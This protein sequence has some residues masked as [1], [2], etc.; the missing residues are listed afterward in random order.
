MIHR[1]RLPGTGCGRHSRS[2]LP[3]ACD[4][5]QRR[6]RVVGVEIE[7]RLQQDV[8][9]A[10]EPDRVVV[11]PVPRHLRILAAAEA[12]LGGPFSIGIVQICLD[13]AL[14][15]LHLGIPVGDRHAVDP[16]H[17][18]ERG[19]VLQWR[20]HPALRRVR[21]IFIFGSVVPRLTMARRNGERQYQYGDA[22]GSNE[23]HCHRSHGAA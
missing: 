9:N 8:G 19:V 18:V 15:L 22:P 4:I 7:D 3:D 21:G 10:I 11:E 6:V 14:A 23:S 5:S 12:V 20:D 17:D 13:C 1:P 2:P 16:R